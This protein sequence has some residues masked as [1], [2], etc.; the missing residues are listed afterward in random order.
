M[1]YWALKSEDFL[2]NQRVQNAEPG[3]QKYTH[4]VVMY[5]IP[6]NPLLQHSIIPI[7]QFNRLRWYKRRFLPIHEDQVFNNQIDVTIHQYAS[8]L[9]C[10]NIKYV[11]D[12]QD[13]RPTKK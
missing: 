1:E 8:C 4:L 10:L 12:K 2:F 5:L 9:E 6:L 3:P 13:G 11:T 7:F